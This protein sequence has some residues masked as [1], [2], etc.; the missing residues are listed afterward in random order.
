MP[1][2][3]N[4]VISHFCRR[5]WLPFPLAL[6]AHSKSCTLYYSAE[7]A[8]SLSSLIE[9][10]VKVLALPKTQICHFAENDAAEK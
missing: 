7:N 1:R 9:L 6:R 2:R 4:G 5:V 8:I 3:R 10:P